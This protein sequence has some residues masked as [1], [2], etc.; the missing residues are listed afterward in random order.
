MAKKKAPAKKEMKKATSTT[1]QALEQAKEKVRKMITNKLITKYDLVLNTTKTGCLQVRRDGEVIM[2]GTRHYF[3]ICEPKEELAKLN[4]PARRCEGNHHMSWIDYEDV[5]PEAIEL[6]LKDKR[7][8][9]EIEK[10]VYSGEMSEAR[11]RY[12]ELRKEAG[13][14][15]KVKAKATQKKTKG[16][17][18]KKAGRPKRAPAAFKS[19]AA[20]ARA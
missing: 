3:K 1:G 13:E 6:R 2:A 16:K 4:V 7:T 18:K 5:T 9:A 14:S 12:F 15:T 10:D 11:R 17:D 20:S 8:N 19:K